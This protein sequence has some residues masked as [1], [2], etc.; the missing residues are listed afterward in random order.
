MRM[1][2]VLNYD[3]S[4]IRALEM[5]GDSQK[6]VVVL[7]VWKHAPISANSSEGL[8]AHQDGRMDEG[9]TCKKGRPDFLIGRRWFKDP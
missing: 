8:S 7:R 1:N 2:P 5:L 6:Q 4:E 9:A 3:L